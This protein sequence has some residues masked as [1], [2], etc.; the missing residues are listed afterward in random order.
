M[1]STPH[2][3]SAFPF[4]P[5]PLKDDDIIFDQKNSFS[6]YW[7]WRHRKPRKRQLKKRR[8]EKKKKKREKRKKEEVEVEDGKSGAKEHRARASVG[9]NSDRTHKMG[10]G[11]YD[12]RGKITKQQKKSL[13]SNV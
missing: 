3:K 4:L 13:H 1:F 12:W 9:D 2:E 11:E 10:P 5:S 8:E 7:N 6:F